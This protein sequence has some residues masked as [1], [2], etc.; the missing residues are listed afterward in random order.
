[1]AATVMLKVMLKVFLRHRKYAHLV[2]EKA[3]LESR[4]KDIKYWG[5][6]SLEKNIK[7]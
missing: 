2:F 5:R 3:N 7:W 4:V 6:K 1:M